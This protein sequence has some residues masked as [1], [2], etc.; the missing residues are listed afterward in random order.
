MVKERVS[1]P[2]VTMRGHSAFYV[3]SAENRCCND[4]S[5]AS[6]YRIRRAYRR[7]GAGPW[8]MD[9]RLTTQD[10]SLSGGSNGLFG[11]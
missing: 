5:V 2:G 7:S 8:Q 1:R 4:E 11:G 10:L 3:G 9:G 6:T